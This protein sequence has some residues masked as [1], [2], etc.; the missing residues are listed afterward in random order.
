[1]VPF[2]KLRASDKLTMS[3]SY[4]YILT[5]SGPHFYKHTMSE[6]NID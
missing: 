5:M 3:G 6:L 2:G 1:M 4:F